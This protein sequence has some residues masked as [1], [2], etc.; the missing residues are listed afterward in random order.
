MQ[1]QYD[2]VIVT[3]SYLVAVV[4]SY[5]ALDMASRVS[6]TRGTSSANY[7]L[8]G[9]A[10]AMGAGIWSMHFVGMLAFSL[11]IPVPYSIP[12]T[13]LSL[14]FAVL[15]SYIALRTI[16]QGSMTRTRLITAGLT[17]GTGIVLM[18]YTGMA[19][20]EILPRPRYDPVLFVLSVIIAV[21]ASM[22]AL[23]ISFQLKSETFSSALWRKLGSALVMGMAIWGMHFTAM[24]AAIFA[25]DTYCLGDPNT[26]DHRWLAFTVGFCTFLLLATTLVVSVFDARLAE[27]NAT[28]KTTRLMNAE[29][30]TRISERTRDLQVS[31]EQLAA[32]NEQLLQA[33]QR[34]NE[35]AHLATVASQAKSE[36][37]ANMSHEI[38]TPMNG[39]IGMTDLLLDGDLTSQQ[40]NFAETIRDSARALLTVINDI[41][42]FSKIEAGKLEL[43]N[44]DFSVCNVVDDVARLIAIQ[45]HAKQLEV[46][47]HVDAAVPAL[48]RGDPV[49]LRQVLLNLCGNAVKF[50]SKGEIE[51]LVQMADTGAAG[52]MLCFKVRDTGIGIA[53]D[54]QQRLFMPFSQVDASTTRKFGGSGLGLSIVK[55]LVEL[56]GG[57][58][59]FESQQGVGSTF[60]F[61]A[62]FGPASEQPSQLD[63]SP[64]LAGCK[65]LVVDDNATNRKVLAAQLRRLGID[66]VC[67][68]SAAE[69]LMMLTQANASDSPFEVA[70]LDHQMP[71]CDG[72]ELGRRIN[73]E[74]AL[75]TTR[76]VLLTSSGQRGDSDHFARL[77]FAGYLPKPVAQRDLAD[78][79]ALTLA[80]QATA[81][82]TQ[83]QPIVTNSQLQTHRG[84]RK[85]RILLAEDNIV[86]EMVACRT[87]ERL[88]Y[89]VD[90]VR[91]GRDAVTAWQTGRYDLI[92][93]DCQMPVLDGYAATREIRQLEGASR[94]IPIVAL[95]AHAMKDD[96]VK[97]KDA[98]MDDYL[99]K[100]I[101]RDRL[102]ACLGRF[103]HAEFS[104]AR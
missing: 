50:T 89:Q 54:H 10:I 24:A 37:L 61:T 14:L 94:H 84:T 65:V 48:L 102:E 55:N 91:N 8:I 82:H 22:A 43:E 1:A 49:R 41:L 23:W 68:S 52:V 70:L 17:M 71:D 3:L 31:N 73:A 72:E 15:A 67:A 93:M 4:A 96:D 77:G 81:W 103:L 79:L 11:P 57:E 12:V 46:S 20:L 9:G 47:A 97:C 80:T 42:D 16:S 7:W 101:D 92:L 58:V 30:E 95:T 18:H 34:A 100:P 6:A 56:M 2:S 13:L 27:R 87:L 19:A 98:G 53:P 32:R 29:L 63:N 33:T 104:A 45:A 75:S 44:T 74:P 60:W 88:G 59:G 25:P 35:L 69:A 86:N 90:P 5:V 51:L 99:T 26:V 36:F 62:R 38:R 78:C 40:R 64:P 39:V 66:A 85:W 28:L 76:L 21:G 83:T